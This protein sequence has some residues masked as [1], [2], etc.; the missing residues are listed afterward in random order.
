MTD[1]KI[2]DEIKTKPR[3]IIDIND[4]PNEAEWVDSMDRFCGKIGRIIDIEDGNYLIEIDEYKDLN[5]TYWW[6]RAWFD[7][8]LR[9]KL[10]KVLND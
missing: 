9:S 10:D 7:A 3:N 4:D 2:G 1:F 8:S 5:R 6:S